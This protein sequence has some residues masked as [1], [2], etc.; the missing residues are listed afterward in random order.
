MSYKYLNP[1]TRKHAETKDYNPAVIEQLLEDKKN[2]IVLATS[3]YSM[4]FKI[5]RYHFEDY[6]GDWEGDESIAECPISTLKNY[7]AL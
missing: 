7:L 2:D 4:S 1:R 6:A 5:F 3:T